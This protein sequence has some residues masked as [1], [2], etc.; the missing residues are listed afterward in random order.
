MSLVTA[1]LFFF[2]PTRTPQNVCCGK[3]WQPGIEQLASHNSWCNY[4][5]KQHFT[6]KNGEIV[7]AKIKDSFIIRVIRFPCRTTAHL[8]LTSSSLCR[9]YSVWHVFTRRLIQIKQV[10]FMHFLLT[11][12]TNCQKQTVSAGNLDSNT[13]NVFWCDLGEVTLWN[14]CLSY[15]FITTCSLLLRIC[16]S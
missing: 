15:P 11:R 16:T 13:K 2:F 6:R 7:S 10:F 9:V 12:G 5:E 4:S 1:V 3:I 8:R 14:N